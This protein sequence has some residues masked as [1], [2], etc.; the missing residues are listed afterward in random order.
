MRH[1]FRAT[2]GETGVQELL[3]PGI[4]GAEMARQELILL[5]VGAKEWAGKVE[6]RRVGD[7][8]MGRLSE[9]REL[10]IGIASEMVEF[11]AHE[12]LIRQGSDAG[13]RAGVAIFCRRLRGAA[14]VGRIVSGG[15]TGD[16]EAVSL[17]CA[18]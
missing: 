14:A 18:A 13:R 7:S 3:N 4:S 1:A 9:G 11:G 5:M 15:V 2:V 8:A 12:F 6:K 16:G 10:Q 17:R